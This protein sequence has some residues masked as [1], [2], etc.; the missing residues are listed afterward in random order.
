MKRI[1]TMSL[2]LAPVDLA[3]VVQ[4]VEPRVVAVHREGNIL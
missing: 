1:E 4:V 2:F 3:H